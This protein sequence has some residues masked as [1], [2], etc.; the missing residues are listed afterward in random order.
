MHI[1]AVLLA[2]G[3][4]SR[5]GSDKRLA[6]LGD[7]RPLL[8]ASAANL[9]A[10]VQDCVVVLERRDFALADEL[11][12]MDFHIQVCE[13]DERGMGHSLAAG[14]NARVEADGWLILPGDMPWIGV[15]TIR[16]VVDV[17]S[18]GADAAV[19][20]YQGKRGHPVGFSSRFRDCLLALHGDRGGRDL[21]DYGDGATRIIDVTDPG[22]CMDADRPEDLLR[23]QAFFSARAPI[24][25]DS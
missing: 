14:I 6:L 9:R 7:G 11:L 25:G 15:G 1:S 8:L 10:V 3:R 21:L 18:E 13:G 4:S 22:V 17:L 19:P 16:C 12:A 5:F 20:S 24:R 23:Y 2:A